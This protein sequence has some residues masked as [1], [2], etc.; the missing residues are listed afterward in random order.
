MTGAISFTTAKSSTLLVPVRLGCIEKFYE[1][2][3]TARRTYR[4]VWNNNCNMG[5]F[6]YVLSAFG[7]THLLIQQTA[8]T[9]ML[10]IVDNFPSESNQSGTT[11]TLFAITL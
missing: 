8:K 1:Y 6:E 2:R 5:I 10:W 3:S 9:F 11:E 4:S 7:I